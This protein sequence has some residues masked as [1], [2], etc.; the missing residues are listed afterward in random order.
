MQRTRT[1]EYIHLFDLFLLYLVFVC[2]C[3]VHLR[4]ANLA[5][6]VYVFCDPAGCRFH[7]LKLFTSEWYGVVHGNGFETS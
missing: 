2:V 5:Q 7:H 1:S 4:R 3:S 6:R